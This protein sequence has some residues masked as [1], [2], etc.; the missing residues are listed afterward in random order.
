MFLT[1]TIELGMNTEHYSD[2]DFSRSLGASRMLVVGG[3]RRAEADDEQ[4]V[5]F[6]VARQA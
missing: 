3:A 1:L 2:A 4:P 5:V 6:P